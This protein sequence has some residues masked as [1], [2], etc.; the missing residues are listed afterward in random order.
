M[1]DDLL[2]EDLRLGPDTCPLTYKKDLDFED[3][4][5][6]VIEL[7]GWEVIGEAEG[8]RYYHSVSLALDPAS[9]SL[10]R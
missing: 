8:N 9:V 10:K 2:V 6:S 4:S 7:V 5:A 3:N 1:I